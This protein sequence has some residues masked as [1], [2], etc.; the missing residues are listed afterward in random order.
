MVFA[1]DVV[2]G[3]FL[4][5]LPYAAGKYFAPAASSTVLAP[6][7]SSMWNMTLDDL[8]KNITFPSQAN[9][10]AGYT[11]VKNAALSA[12]ASPFSFTLD[13][14]LLSEAIVGF[15]FAL[16]SIAAWRI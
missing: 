14:T 2:V 1:S 7:V 4:L 12:S 9:V 8:S 5:C 15:L 6:F 16:F 11:G 10:L 3:A 13:S